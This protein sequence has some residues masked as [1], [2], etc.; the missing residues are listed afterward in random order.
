MIRQHSNHNITD[1]FN[2]TFNKV[3][4]SKK[5]NELI[6]F[7]QT[8]SSTYTSKE[9]LKSYELRNT[10]GINLIQNIRYLLIKIL[11]NCSP[12]KPSLYG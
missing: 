6:E 4:N 10:M 3:F 9:L 12:K 11:L 1:W 2:K 7:L 5:Y 8:D